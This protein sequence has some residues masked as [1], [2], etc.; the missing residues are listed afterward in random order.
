MGVSA[1]SFIGRREFSGRREFYYFGESFIASRRGWT[2]KP[3]DVLQV[4]SGPCVLAMDVEVWVVLCVSAQRH[5]ELAPGSQG[6]QG[7]PSHVLE[8]QLADGA[9]VTGR[10]TLCAGAGGPE[11]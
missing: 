10:D 5:E 2:S 4:W 8:V 6:L 1:G 11:S 3:Q 9:P 7:V